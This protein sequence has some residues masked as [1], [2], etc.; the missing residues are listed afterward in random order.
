MTREKAYEILKEF[1]KS[2]NLIK[3]HLAAEATMRGLAK[4]FG[5]KGSN[6]NVE[7]WGL[8][9]LLHDADYEET[10]D[11]P[12]KHTAVLE[13]KLKNDLRPEI[14]NAIKAHAYGYNKNGVEPKSYM[15]WAIYTCDEL[16][17]FIIACALVRPDKKLASVDKEIV[18]KKLKEP[19]FAR[20][21]D[22]NQIRMCEEKLG[23]P[24]EQFIKIALE[25]MQKISDELGL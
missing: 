7:D 1:I 14:L 8:V 20:A 11:T 17:G 22:R 4:Y 12:E 18:L 16:T 10:K 15:D 5:A 19:G 6:I 3:H 13:E 21:V 2:P 25:S 24:L 23:I 9:G